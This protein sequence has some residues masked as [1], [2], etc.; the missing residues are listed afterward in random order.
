MREIDSYSPSNTALSSEFSFGGIYSEG[1]MEV[2]LTFLVRRRLLGWRE[3]GRN[4]GYGISSAHGGSKGVR[5]EN[6]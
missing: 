1:G 4:G 6:L 2:G 5:W 3:V